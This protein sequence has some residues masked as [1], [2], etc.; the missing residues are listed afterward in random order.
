MPFQPRPE[1]IK[2]L[3][4]ISEDLFDATKP[5][6]VTIRID[7]TNDP[8]YPVLGEARAPGVSSLTGG[9]SQVGYKPM[10]IHQ[11]STL[12]FIRDRRKMLVQRDVRVDPPRIPELLDYYGCLSQMLTPVEWKRRFV[13]IVSVH[14]IE[15]RDWTEQDKAAIKDATLRVERELEQATWFDITC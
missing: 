3:Q 15:Q 12:I 8:D 10:D 5:A 1:L 14:N 2:D 6:R 13:G 7:T 9:M 4:A 11:T